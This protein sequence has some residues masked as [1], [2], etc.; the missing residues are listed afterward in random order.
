MHEELMRNTGV[1]P[2]ELPTLELLQDGIVRL[3]DR[4]Y[5]LCRRRLLRDRE[6]DQNLATTGDVRFDQN[7]NQGADHLVGPALLHSL[8]P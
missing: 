6:R 4:P 1:P 2:R 7:A 8:I 5:G 3:R